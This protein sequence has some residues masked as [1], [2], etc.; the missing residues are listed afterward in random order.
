M[1]A[2]EL[3]ANVRWFLANALAQSGTSHNQSLVVDQMKAAANNP[4]ANESPSTFAQALQEAPLTGETVDQVSVDLASENPYVREAAVSILT[5]QGTVEAAQKLYDHTV[6]RGDPD[7][8]YRDGMGIAA[9]HPQAETLPYLEQLIEQRDQYSHLAVKALLNYGREGLDKVIE[10]IATSK[11]IPGDSKLLHNAS[12]HIANDPNTLALMNS[13][14]SS[15]NKA[16]RNLAD[17]VLREKGID[18]DNLNKQIEYN[19]NWADNII[20]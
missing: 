20:R 4:N 9:M 17:T 19:D 13:L 11:D 12:D 2:P 14:S 10:M 16:L 7:G 8:Y 1:T 6:E 3:P 15:P 18:R 5:K